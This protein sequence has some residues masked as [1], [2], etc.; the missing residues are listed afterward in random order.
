MDFLLGLI[1]GM[2]VG[3]VFRSQVIKLYEVTLKKWMSGTT[4]K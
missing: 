4:G 1:A 2:A 3:V